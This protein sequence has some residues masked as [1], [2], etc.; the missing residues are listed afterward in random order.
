MPGVQ[1]NNGGA[2]RLPALEL[3]PSYYTPTPEEIGFLKSQTGIKD[4]EELRQHVLTVQK[5]AW[6]VRLDRLVHP[7]IT[8]DK[9]TY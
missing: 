3:D 1:S 9:N 4:E 6:N 8:T 2:P 7:L 5:E